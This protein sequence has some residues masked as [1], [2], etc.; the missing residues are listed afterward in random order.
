MGENRKKKIQTDKKWVTKLYTYMYT[1]GTVELLWMEMDACTTN[2]YENYRF[3]CM[4][5]PFR[6]Q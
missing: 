2:I 1:M 5:C 4:M 3:G 6:Q